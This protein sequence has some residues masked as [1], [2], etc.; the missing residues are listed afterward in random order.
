[1][2]LA[3][4]QLASFL[5]S[6]GIF[7]CVSCNYFIPFQNVIFNTENVRCR[8]CGTPVTETY[9][10]CQPCDQ[11]SRLEVYIITCARIPGHGYYS[12]MPVGIR[13]R[14]MGEL[15]RSI[16]PE[17]GCVFGKFFSLLLRLIY[18]FKFIILIY[19]WCVS[20]SNGANWCVS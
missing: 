6:C 7:E 4:S 12:N 15:C 20:D 19:S 16:N 1:M 18:I 17:R 13:F 14:R 5:G 9:V 3:N 8:T 11:V 2:S 10:Y